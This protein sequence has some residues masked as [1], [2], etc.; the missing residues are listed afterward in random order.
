[1]I[2]TLQVCSITKL[3]NLCNTVT[4]SWQ[5]ADRYYCEYLDQ[6]QNLFFVDVKLC[7]RQLLHLGK[8]NSSKILIFLEIESCLI[9]QCL[10]MTALKTNRIN[11]C[12]PTS[13]ITSRSSVCGI[14]MTPV[15]LHLSV[16]CVSPGCVRK[17][18]AVSR[19]GTAGP[20]GGPAAPAA[21]LSSTKQGATQ[22]SFSHHPNHEDNFNWIQSEFKIC[23]PGRTQ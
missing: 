10:E 14:T 15:T 8:E 12:L 9:S 22:A 13:L 6:K 7:N 4:H 11:A 2:S 21:C 19:R 16:S 20:P 3:V 5:S 18:T 23:S 17:S 1:M